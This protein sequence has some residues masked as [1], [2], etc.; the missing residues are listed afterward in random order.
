MTK[1]IRVLYSIYDFLG[2]NINFEEYSVEAL[3][4]AL[5]SYYRNLPFKLFPETSLV[6]FETLALKSDFQEQVK[7]INKIIMPHLSPQ[8]QKLCGFLCIFLR[9]VA[10]NEE[11][12]L[13]NAPA[14]AAIWA[15]N[16]VHIEDERRLFAKFPVISNFVMH[17]INNA[18]ELFGDME[19]YPEPLN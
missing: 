19:F 16:L 9:K 4:S 14:L 13:M 15:N 2:Y 12:T 3:A 1:V 5:K 10:D 8:K 11:K 6:S 18:N 7:Y 17:L